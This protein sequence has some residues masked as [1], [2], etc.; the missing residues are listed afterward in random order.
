MYFKSKNEYTEIGG[1]VYKNAFLYPNLIDDYNNL[2]K[3]SKIISLKHSLMSLSLNDNSIKESN[4]NLQKVQIIRDNGQDLL[5]N[6]NISITLPTIELNQVTGLYEIKDDEFETLTNEINELHGYVHLADKKKLDE[7]VNIE[8]IKR[9]S[10]KN[11]LVMPQRYSLAIDQGVINDS[12][13]ITNKWDYLSIFLVP[14]I[15][16]EDKTTYIDLNIRDII[17]PYNV[18]LTPE[19]PSTTFGDM[20]FQKFQHE[21]EQL[22]DLN[23]FEL[24]TSQELND[25]LTSLGVSNFSI[26][27]GGGGNH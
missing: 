26:K 11:E 6:V 19:L 20:I 12:H 13:I 24:V 22:L 21:Y 3:N 1:V 27:Q 25:W 17:L 16:Y 8:V 18:N 23:Q 5:F 4:F 2:E 15:P 14:L 7:E 10:S 9:L